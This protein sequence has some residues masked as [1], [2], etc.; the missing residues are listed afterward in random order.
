[1]NSSVD[2]L[3][4]FEN[5]TKMDMKSLNTSTTSAAADESSVILSSAAKDT[6]DD[7]DENTGSYTKKDNVGDFNNEINKIQKDVL[8]ILQRLENTSI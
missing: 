5:S 6:L 1:M 2:H 8:K 4:H 3:S 7:Y